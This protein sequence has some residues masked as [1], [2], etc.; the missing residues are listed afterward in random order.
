MYKVPADAEASDDKKVYIY[1][2]N[3]NALTVNET[4]CKAKSGCEFEVKASSD[5]SATLYLGES[6]KENK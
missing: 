4:E 2:S 5:T 1:V 6:Q 3:K